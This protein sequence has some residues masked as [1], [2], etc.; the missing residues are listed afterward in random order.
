MLNLFPALRR[1]ATLLGGRLSGGEQQMLA[2]AR[3]LMSTPKMLLLDEPSMG[4]APLIIEDIFDILRK[5][6][7][8]GTTILLV[9]QNARLALAFAE[10]GYVLL[11]GE[12]IKSGGREAMMEEEFVK[13]AYLG[14]RN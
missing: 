2:I 7:D 9:E 5:I 14:Q 4:L 1:R 6:N 8:D 13:K 3:S 12:V 10:R 11:A